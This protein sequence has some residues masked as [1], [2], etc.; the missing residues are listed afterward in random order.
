VQYDLDLRRVDAAGETTFAHTDLE[1]LPD[2]V[3]YV[4]YGAWTD[5]GD[6]ELQTDVDGDGTIDDTEALPDEAPVEGEDVCG[7]DV[8]P[9]DPACAAPADATLELEIDPSLICDPDGV[10]VDAK[11]DLITPDAETPEVTPEPIE[12]GAEPIDPNAAPADPNHDLGDPNGD[13][14]ADPNADPPDATVVPT[15]PAAEATDPSAAP[16]DT[17]TWNGWPLPAQAP[18]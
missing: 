15:D 12:P 11:G 13:P 17:S 9:D 16:A 1:Y 2:S 6:L 4:D 7:P 3:V 18:G 14:N 10:C 5:E 8:A